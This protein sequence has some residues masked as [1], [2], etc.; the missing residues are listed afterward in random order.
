MSYYGG[1]DSDGNDKNPRQM[2]IDA[3]TQAFNN[4]VDFAQYDTDNDGYVDNVFIYYA[5]YNEAEGASANTVWPHRWT[6]A[7]A[8]TT[9]NGKIVYDYAC[10]SELKGKSG[11]NMATKRKTP[12]NAP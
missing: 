6:L 2:V 9:F 4:G 11:T 12:A 1:N 3:C 8:N 10:T 5:G 7:N